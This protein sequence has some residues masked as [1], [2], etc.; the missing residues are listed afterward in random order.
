MNIWI[1]GAK[2]VNVHPQQNKKFVS[3]EVLVN[4]TYQNVQNWEEYIIRATQL[5]GVRDIS[6]PTNY[7]PWPNFWVG[8]EPQ[9]AFI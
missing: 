9:R 3:H 1:S 2:S 7:D 6:L 5:R 8:A 4:N